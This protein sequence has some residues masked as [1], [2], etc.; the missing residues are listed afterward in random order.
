[1]TPITHDALAGLSS[2]DQGPCLSLYQQTHRH[3]PE[4]QQDPIQFRNL[5]KRLEATLRERYP[6]A[7]LP[8]LLKPFEALANDGAFWNHTLD[9]LAVLASE[10]VF[11]ALRIPQP[12]Q[13][14]VVVADTFHTRPL[15]RFLQSVDRFQVLALSRDSARFFEGN[16]YALDE[17]DLVPEVPGT[18]EQALGSELTEPH[19]TVASYA[20]V[21]T[22]SNAMHHGHGGKPD[23]LDIDDER[24]FRAV[25]RAVLEHYSRPSG[26]P[27][28]LAALPEH[29]HLFHRVSQNPFLLEDGIRVHP[30]SVSPD[31]FRALAWAVVEPRYH[32]R[33]DTL[34]S[35]FEEARAHGLGSDDV[36]QV[37]KAAV[38]G[39]VSTLLI[40]ADR[41][42]VGQLDGATGRVEFVSPPSLQVNDLLDDL[43]EMVA[44][45]GGRGFVIP[46][47]RMPTMTG[48]AAIYRY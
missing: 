34:V 16:Q 44:R 37:A 10:G 3:F 24:Y 42:I 43:G 11:Q 36:A 20:G 40:E 27:L 12:V 38:A 46:R 39:R 33:L 6:E 31:K 32:A 2:P 28:I 19:M 5:V 30:S 1:M 45:M 23:E 25:D 35:E 26:L 17:V 8:K 7:E 14:L 48:L 22:G 4:N 21:G 15:Q 13:E 29:H 18:I 47:D 41:E 9:G